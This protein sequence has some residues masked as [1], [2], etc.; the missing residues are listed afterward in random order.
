MNGCF[1]LSTHISF[2]YSIISCNGGQMVSQ[3]TGIASHSDSCSLF[4][5]VEVLMID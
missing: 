4:V 2:A 5:S 1:H 3:R